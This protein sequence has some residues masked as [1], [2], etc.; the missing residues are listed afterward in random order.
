MRVAV[1]VD[2]GYLYAAGG[3]VLTGSLQ[4]RAALELLTEEIIAKLKKV[5]S[6]LTNGVQLLRIIWYDGLMNGRRSAEQRV[7]A[8][9]ND[10]KLRLGTVSGGRQK[11]VDTLIVIDLM[12]LARNQAISDAVLLSGDED[13]RVGVV[14]AQRY[15]VRVHLIGITPS[16][17]NQSN[18]LQE[19]VDTVTEWGRQDIEKVLSVKSE[20]AATL[21]V[22]TGIDV[23]ADGQP[24]DVL[25][26]VVTAV[27]SSISDG[28]L[29][30]VAANLTAHPNFIPHHF[31]QSLLAT[32][33]ESLGRDLDEPEK[34]F[35]RATFR[36]IVN[37]RAEQTN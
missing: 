17:D 1:F 24:N 8:K 18:A 4:N 20:A 32:G 33:R 27:A 7:L 14:I 5:A 6:D 25:A 12:D 10:V 31:D 28:E 29:S 19:E 11:G 2:A 30:T 35:A 37:L 26:S 21:E 13:L 23:G 22:P 16:G 15:G 3:K 36:A 9:T 34:R